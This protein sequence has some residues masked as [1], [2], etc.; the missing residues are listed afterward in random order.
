MAASDPINPVKRETLLGDIET[1]R[2]ISEGLLRDFG[3]QNNF[4]NRYQTDI[5]E[6]KLNGS[7]SVATG[8]TFFDGVASFFY[9]SEIVGIQIYNG[10]SGSSGTT[11]FD[12]KWIDTSGVDQGSIFSV[13][14]KI[15]STS[16]NE[17]VG[18]R[19]LTTGTDVSPTGVTLPTF[20]K[21]EFLEGE[22]VYLELKT[23]MAAAKNCGL[24]IFYKPIN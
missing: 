18:F 10:V 12:L 19:N 22:S 5:K 6:F 11:E 21:T 9:N 8:I 1:N 13:T 23:S 16:S 24:T 20:S 7:Y 14:P 2:P 15:N 3:A 17:T 4:V